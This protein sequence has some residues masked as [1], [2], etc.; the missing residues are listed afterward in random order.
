MYLNRKKYKYILILQREIC[1]FAVC[2]SIFGYY[3]FCP[4]FCVYVLRWL[5][6]AG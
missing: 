2:F 4:P 5:L 6:T 1:Y 3:A